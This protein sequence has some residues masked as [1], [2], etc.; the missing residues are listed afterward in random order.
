MPTLRRQSTTT[1]SRVKTPTLFRPM[2]LSR[3]PSH[4]CLR[5]NTKNLP[6][7]RYRSVIRLG[8]TTEVQDTIANGGR[9]IEINSVQS[10]R[11][12]SSKLLMKQCF[13]R[14]GVKTAPRFINGNFD[15][16]RSENY[17]FV[18]NIHFGSK[19]S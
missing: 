7:S 2:I 15:T 9:R 1:T 4:K 10:I 17:P 12:S 3:H 16:W 6:L 18:P 13:E 19:G 11:N 14:A 5:A 8:S